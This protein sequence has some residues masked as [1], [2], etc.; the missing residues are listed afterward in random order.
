M[1]FKTL[2]VEIDRLSFPGHRQEIQVKTFRHRR[3]FLF[4]D[5]DHDVNLNVYIRRSRITD[6]EG[7]VGLVAGG[8]LSDGHST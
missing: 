6:S 4:R 7:R 5:T 1:T 3:A 2:L 8:A